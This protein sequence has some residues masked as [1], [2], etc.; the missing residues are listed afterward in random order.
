MQELDLL[1]ELNL[2]DGEREQAIMD[3]FGSG[4]VG[5]AS[6]AGAAVEATSHIA[7]VVDGGPEAETQVLRETAKS[8]PSA[9]SECEYRISAFVGLRER[10]CKGEV[11]VEMRARWD[12][13][14]PTV[15]MGGIVVC[16]YFL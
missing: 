15:S 14:S 9:A 7:Q 2:L 4:V 12:G 5:T 3:P 11:T 13:F 6:G 1:D 16:T 10:M 8:S